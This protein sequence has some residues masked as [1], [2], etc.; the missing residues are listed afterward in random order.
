MS[1]DLLY[2]SCPVVAG[3]S[4][5]TDMTGCIF[6]VGGNSR[7]KAWRP[8]PIASITLKGPTLLMKSDLNIVK[9]VDENKIELCRLFEKIFKRL[10]SSVSHRSRL[11]CVNRTIFLVI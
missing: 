4:W 10:F 9:H 11:F 6:M 5:V 3:S 1:V 2:G 7:R 8:F